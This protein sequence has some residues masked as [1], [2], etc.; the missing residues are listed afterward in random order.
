MEG[1]IVA[2]FAEYCIITVVTISGIQQ[3]DPS[4]SASFFFCQSSCL[5]IQ[6]ICL[7]KESTGLLLNHVVICYILKLQSKLLFIL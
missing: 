3:N 6:F 1:Y 2:V 5:D 4:F 7:G